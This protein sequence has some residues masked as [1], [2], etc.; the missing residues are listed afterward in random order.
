VCVD[1]QAWSAGIR[2][3]SK[4]MILFDFD[5]LTIYCCLGVIL[6]D[7]YLYIRD[8]LKVKLPKERGVEIEFDISL[9][10][11]LS[12]FQRVVICEKKGNKIVGISEGSS[13]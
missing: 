2:F 7:S 12:P 13:G 9:C 10:I 3:E 4:K 11:F 6:E 5:Q 1:H 8:A